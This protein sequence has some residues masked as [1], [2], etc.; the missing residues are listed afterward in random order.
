MLIGLG[1]P[2]KEYE[3]TRHNFGFMLID[4]L[5]ASQSGP[6]GVADKLAA[7][8]THELWKI[9]LSPP[10]ALPWLLLKPLTYMNNSGQPGAAVAS[11][12]NVCP[13]NHSA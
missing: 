4:E 7:R 8:K 1:N 3:N 11:Y 5:L 10:P 2:G 6:F 13:E 12:Y 9:F